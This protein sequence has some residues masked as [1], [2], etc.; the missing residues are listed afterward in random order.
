MGR[1]EE[2]RGLEERI[3][4]L[5]ACPAGGWI[6]LAIGIYVVGKGRKSIKRVVKRAFRRL[7]LVLV[8]ILVLVRSNCKQVYAIERKVVVVIMPTIGL[9]YTLRAMSKEKL[10]CFGSCRDFDT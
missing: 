2:N 9:V 7:L 5:V 1:R 6:R 10:K 4:S 3:R 8:L